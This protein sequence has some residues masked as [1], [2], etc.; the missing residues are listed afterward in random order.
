MSS[1]I[2]RGKW[3][4]VHMTLLDFTVKQQNTTSSKISCMKEGKMSNI[5]NIGH[6]EVI[7]MAGTRDD[8]REGYKKNLTT[9]G[10]LN[11]IPGFIYQTK[12]ILT[13]SEMGDTDEKEEKFSDAVDGEEE[14][15]KKKKEK[16][17]KNEKKEKKEKKEKNPE[18]KNDPGKLK[19]KLDKIGSKIQA[20]NE[21]REEILKLLEEAEAKAPPPE[22]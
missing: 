12:F 19:A 1:T 7:C 20:L 21:K 13:S 9:P 10:S 4:Q 15:D 6:D 2:V 8:I 18:D 5:F 17:E 16:K 11:S 3:L 14:K 22:A